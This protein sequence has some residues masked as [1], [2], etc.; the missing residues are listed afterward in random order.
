MHQK[1]VKQL[2]TAL[3]GIKLKDA[4]EAVGIDLYSLARNNTLF[5]PSA[6]AIFV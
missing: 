1:D 5:L 4:R 3:D 6:N 2:W